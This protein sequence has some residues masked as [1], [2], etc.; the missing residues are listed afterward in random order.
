MSVVPAP[1]EP[2]QKQP[3]ET[4]VGTTGTVTVSSWATKIRM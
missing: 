4:D 1:G 2:A 3:I